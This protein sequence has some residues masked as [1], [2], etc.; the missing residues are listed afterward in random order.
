M[1]LAL[2]PPLWF[3]VMNNEVERYKATLEGINLA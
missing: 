2:I 1:V 3:N